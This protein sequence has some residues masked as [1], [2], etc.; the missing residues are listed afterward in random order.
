MSQ[1]YI[2]HH[3][4]TKQQSDG[5]STEAPTL[6]DAFEVWQLAATGRRAHEGVTTVMKMRY[7][8]EID[9]LHQLDAVD[10]SACHQTGCRCSNTQPQQALST[11]KLACNRC[12]GQ[13]N[14]MV[15]SQTA[16]LELE[17][18]ELTAAVGTGHACNSKRMQEARRTT[19]PVMPWNRHILH[20]SIAYSHS[21]NSHSQPACHTLKMQLL[22][23]AAYQT[24]AGS[25][26]PTVSGITDAVRPPTTALM[27]VPLQA[28]AT[29]ASICAAD[30]QR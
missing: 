11:P 18:A 19:H 26:T 20:S 24:A 13:P 21:L 5:S 1:R 9:P 10:V 14:T 30:N 12:C 22:G 3:R 8:C 15:Q 27:A 23:A 7:S 6:H 25:H 28:K 4:N 17:A 16:A 2:Q 29:L